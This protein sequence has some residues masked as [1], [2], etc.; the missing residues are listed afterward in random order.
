MFCHVLF[1]K[2]APFRNRKL[3]LSIFSG[4]FSMT[5]QWRLIVFY[6]G[7]NKLLCLPSFLLLAVCLSWLNIQ[8]PG[9]LYFCSLVNT[10]WRCNGVPDIQE[11]LYITAALVEPFVFYEKQDTYCVIQALFWGLQLCLG[12]CLCVK[13]IWQK[14]VAFCFKCRV[15]DITFCFVFFSFP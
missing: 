2:D 9:C 5:V 12:S 3:D 10:S 1:L 4:F 14:C 8:R 6:S 15:R 7:W 13:P 11:V